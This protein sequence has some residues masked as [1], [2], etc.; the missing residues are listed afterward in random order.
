MEGGDGEGGKGWGWM[1]AKVSVCRSETMFN[2][3]WHLCQTV[4]P[5]PLRT[6]RPSGFLYLRDLPLCCLPAQT[7][8]LAFC[9][10]DDMNEIWPVTFFFFFLMWWHG[11]PWRVM[12]SLLL[13]VR[14]VCIPLLASCGLS[15]ASGIDWRPAGRE[16]FYV[17]YPWP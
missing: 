2:I 17:S 3:T 8:R 13:L 16:Q 14:P 4:S 5:P 6:H 10:P 12:C 11:K 9:K 15:E 7:L 1:G